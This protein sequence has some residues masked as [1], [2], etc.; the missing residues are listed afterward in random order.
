MLHQ[1][2][3]GIVKLFDQLPVLGHY[4]VQ[5]SS[6]NIIDYSYPDG[7]SVSSNLIVEPFAALL[8]ALGIVLTNTSPCPPAWHHSTAVQ[9]AFPYMVNA[10]CTAVHGEKVQFS[11]KT[12]CHLPFS[13]LGMINLWFICIYK[14]INNFNIK[15]LHILS[16]FKGTV[17]REKYGVYQVRSC[18]WPRQWSVYILANLHKRFTNLHS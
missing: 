11:Q 15:K 14:E 9:S 13:Y 16:F 7:Q 3:P 18:F 4:P 2:H 1:H 8:W 10:N 5:G 17:S 6:F 12:R